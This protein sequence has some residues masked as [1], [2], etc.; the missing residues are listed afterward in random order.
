MCCAQNIVEVPLVGAGTIPH[1]SEAWFKAAG[2]VL[3][4]ASEGTG[5]IAGAS[6]CCC[7]CANQLCALT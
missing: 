2:V 3:Q 1:R 7:C 6:R 5:V 4:P